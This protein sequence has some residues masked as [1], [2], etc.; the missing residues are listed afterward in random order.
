[1]SDHRKF[2]RQTA[3]HFAYSFRRRQEG[4]VIAGPVSD[5]IAAED[6]WTSIRDA[7]DDRRRRPMLGRDRAGQKQLFLRGFQRD[8]SKPHKDK[9]LPGW[10]GV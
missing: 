5:A 8:I 9:R 6:V 10:E 4:R 7:P 1:M 3:S 2:V